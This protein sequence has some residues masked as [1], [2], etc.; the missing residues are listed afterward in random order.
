MQMPARRRHFAFG[1]VQFY[2][3]AGPRIS[4]LL[5]AGLHD[6]AMSDSFSIAASGMRA[7]SLWLEAAASNIANMHDTSPVADPA[8][9][10]ASGGGQVYQPVSVAQSARPGGGV[11]ASLQPVQPPSTLAYNP[12]SPFANMQGMV[13]APNVDPASEFVNMAQAAHSFRANVAVFKVASHIAKTM[14]DIFT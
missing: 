11:T 1:S 10:L 8:Q 4:V 13:A 5:T 12:G 7:A 14:L 3:N 2:S 9:V 6:P